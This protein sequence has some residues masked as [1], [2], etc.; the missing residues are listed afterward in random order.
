MFIRLEICN[1]K[2]KND[3]FQFNLFFNESVMKL[4]IF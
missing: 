4:K 1:I 3:Y 2:I